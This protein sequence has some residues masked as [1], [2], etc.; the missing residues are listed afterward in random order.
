M[1]KLLLSAALCALASP[2]FASP[3]E[4]SFSMSLLGNLDTPLSGEGL[5]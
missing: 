4:G 3:S 1:N 5:H 2:A